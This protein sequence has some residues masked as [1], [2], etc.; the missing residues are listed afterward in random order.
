MGRGQGPLLDNPHADE[1]D[2]S[3]QPFIDSLKNEAPCWVSRHCFRPSEGDRRLKDMLQP[4]IDQGVLTV[5]YETVPKRVRIEGGRIVS[6]VFVQRTYT[7][8]GPEPYTRRLS[9]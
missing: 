4:F 7:G 1:A 9:R 6:A 3:L 5:Y 8:V 2:R